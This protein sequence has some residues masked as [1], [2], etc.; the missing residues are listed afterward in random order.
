MDDIDGECSLVCFVLDSE[1]ISSL[2]SRNISV[3]MFINAISIFLPWV[4]LVGSRDSLRMTA[5]AIKG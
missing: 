5:S 2:F 3:N 4:V 1:I